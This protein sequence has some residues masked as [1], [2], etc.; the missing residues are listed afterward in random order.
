LSIPIR[1]A[2]AEIINKIMLWGQYVGPVLPQQEN[3]HHWML[4]TVHGDTE[5][6]EGANN[7]QPILCWGYGV[8]EEVQWQRKS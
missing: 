5:R 1:H 4:I 6:L 7:N 2:I 3:F 8:Q